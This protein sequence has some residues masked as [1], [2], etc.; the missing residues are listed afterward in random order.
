MKNNK[1]PGSDGL[2]VEFYKIFWKYIKQHYINSINY[3]FAQGELTNLQKQGIITL[4]P[5]T[6]KESIFLSNWRPI[7]LLNV[8]YKIATKSIA[9]RIKKVLPN[10]ISSEQT[11]FMKGRYI[12]ENVRLI[13]EIIEYAEEYNQPCLLFFSDYEKAFDSLNHD[14]IYKCLNHMNFGESVIKW[15]RLFYH[16]AT[17]IIINNGN[18]SEDFPIERGV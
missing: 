10:V 6:G 2:S 18:M 17:S 5:K 16:Q 7:S 13:F 1:S 9:N 4:L 8:D 14:F 11:G 12:G 15:I 3:S